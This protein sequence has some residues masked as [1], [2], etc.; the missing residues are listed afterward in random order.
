LGPD[1][2]VP[3]VA[4]ATCFVAYLVGTRTVFPGGDRATV[5]VRLVLVAAAVGAVT[6]LTTIALTE[7]ES[8]WHS[9]AGTL[10]FAGALVLFLAAAGATRPRRLT[11]VFSRDVPRHVVRTGPYRLV[12]H[13][14]YAAYLLTYLAGLVVTGLPVLLV[15]L[16]AMG[17]LYAT[18]ARREEQ[19]FRH[20]A[21]AEQYRDYAARTGMFWPAGPW[22][23]GRD[24]D[25]QLPE[26][27]AA[28]DEHPAAG[29]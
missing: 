11:P 15:V 6:E 16:V 14:F 10:T 9:A 5:G 1:R 4:G 17:T 13:P 29:P 27:V 23:S 8:A 24:R 20:S 21:L 22:R 12:R 26:R 19:K 2:I 25:D 28:V 7:P 3:L 18:A